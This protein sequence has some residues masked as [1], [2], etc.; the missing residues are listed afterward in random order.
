VSR[1]ALRS[2]MCVSFD[3]AD[4]VPALVTPA[5]GAAAHDGIDGF[6]DS[7]MSEPATGRRRPE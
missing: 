3:P 4:P 2:L 1:A 6:R 5:W 7:V